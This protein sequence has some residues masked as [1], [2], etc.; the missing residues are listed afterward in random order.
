MLKVNALR[1]FFFLLIAAIAALSIVSLAGFISDL[2][3]GR[4]A[5]RVGADLRKLNLIAL[6]MLRSDL[7]LEPGMIRKLAAG[8]IAGTDPWGTE[9]KMIGAGRGA[10]WGSAGHDGIWNTR[11]DISLT[12]A[13]VAAEVPDRELANE[14]R[15][16]EN[17][18][19]LRAQ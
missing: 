18:A 15:A 2:R 6:A 11:D 13:K 19:A 12:L 16:L 1:S 17:G 5:A 3:H 14:R 7:R 10:R 4:Q 8:A 9:Y